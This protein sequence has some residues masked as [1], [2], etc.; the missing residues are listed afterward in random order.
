MK[1][2]KIRNA[3]GLD[4]EI[5]RRRLRLKEI[6]STLGKNMVDLPGQVPK[7]A[8]YAFLGKKQK[9]DIGG[10]LPGQ[11]MMMA[12]E[13]EKLQSSLADLIDRIADKIG[14]GIQKLTHAVL[15]RKKDP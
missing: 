10:G 7:M 14:E 9:A 5:Y 4:R 11:L 15:D 1:S 12:M 2:T 3:E 8:L 6:E 13:N